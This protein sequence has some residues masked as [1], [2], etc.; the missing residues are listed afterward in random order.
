MAVAELLGTTACLLLLRVATVNAAF[1]QSG[2]AN[3]AVAGWR[4]RVR[5]RC[6]CHFGCPGSFNQ[7]DADMSLTV[8]GTVDYGDLA[9]SFAHLMRDD[10]VCATLI[11]DAHQRLVTQS[12]EASWLLGSSVPFKSGARADSSSVLPRRTIGLTTS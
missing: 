2:P 11:F 5:V 8:R 7:Y 9:L 1:R 12:S 4:V 6:G 3:G 10:M